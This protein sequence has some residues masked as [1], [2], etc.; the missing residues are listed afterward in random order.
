MLN[1]DHYFICFYFKHQFQLLV[2]R[3]HTKG[4][5]RFEYGMGHI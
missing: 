5:L 4:D 2:N 1:V 3:Q